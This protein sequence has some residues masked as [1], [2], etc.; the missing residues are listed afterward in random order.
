MG[1]KEAIIFAAGFVA[2][3]LVVNKLVE[4]KYEDSIY[5]IVYC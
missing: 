1:I 2:G 4:K 3:G 5:I